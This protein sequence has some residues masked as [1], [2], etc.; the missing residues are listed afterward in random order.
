MWQF[1]SETCTSTIRDAVGVLICLN[2]WVRSSSPHTHKA[3]NPDF[4]VNVK[5][6]QHFNSHKYLINEMKRAISTTPMAGRTQLLDFH[7]HLVHITASN[8]AAYSL[9]LLLPML[10]ICIADDDDVDDADDD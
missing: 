8:T 6:K 7:L 2:R 1:G 3:V 10:L 9:L 4:R 5:N